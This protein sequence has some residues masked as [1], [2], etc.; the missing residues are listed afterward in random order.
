MSTITVYRAPGSLR[1]VEGEHKPSVG[2]VC[3][4]TNATLAEVLAIEHAHTVARAEAPQWETGQMYSTGGYRAHAT[5]R[6]VQT[7]DQEVGHCGVDYF[8]KRR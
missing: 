7:P 1:I 4:Y 5:T 2:T 3:V 6:I 8:E